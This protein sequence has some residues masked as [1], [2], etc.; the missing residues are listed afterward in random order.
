MK[1]PPP[2]L[3]SGLKAKIQKVPQDEY[4]VELLSVCHKT[5]VWNVEISL[6]G[7][8]GLPKKKKKICL[9]SQLPL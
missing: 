1:L 5:A 6:T 3:Y 2:N 7:L 8:H 4:Q 9:Q